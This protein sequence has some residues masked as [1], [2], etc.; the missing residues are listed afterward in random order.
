MRSAVLAL[1]LMVPVIVVLPPTLLALASTGKFCKP[2][3]PLSMSRKS[4]GVTPSSCR[5][6]PKPPLSRTTL[7]M[8]VL[9]V[10]ALVFSAIA[11]LTLNAIRLPAPMPPIRLL[12][13]WL[14][15]YTPALPN[16]QPLPNEA[17]PVRSVPIQLPCTLLPVEALPKIKM[18]SSA[19][20]EI[21]LPAPGAV[22]PTCVFDA[23]M[24]ITP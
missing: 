3:E 8:M 5:S 16:R 17:V 11:L 15:M 6:S 23:P 22:P 9:P 4:F 19:L 10:P 18:P 20:P 2:F 12:R 1:L 24:N 7:P 14:S 21:T 13:A